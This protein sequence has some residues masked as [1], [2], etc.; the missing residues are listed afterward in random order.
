ML[1]PSYTIKWF[2][3]LCREFSLQWTNQRGRWTSVPPANLLYRTA[4][5][6]S[7]DQ[8]IKARRFGC[9]IS[10]LTGM[11]NSD[12]HAHRRTN[13]IFISENF[14][15][16]FDCPTKDFSCLYPSL[17]TKR[18]LQNFS[19]SCGKTQLDSQ[20]MLGPSSQLVT[21]TMC[22]PDVEDMRH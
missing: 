21:R 1:P 14:V 2:W 20:T 16:F 22:V 4:I 7:V 9:F 8:V 5:N 10:W 6:I 15:L 3:R 11:G 17:P 18:L 19:S 12:T 13:C